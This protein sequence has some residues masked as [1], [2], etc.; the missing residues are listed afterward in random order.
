MPA[1]ATRGATL[2]LFCALSLNAGAT[3]PT[4]PERTLLSSP[5]KAVGE[6]QLTDQ[7]GRPF[8]SAQLLG[9]PTLVF[10]GFTNCPDVCPVTMQRLTLFKRNHPELA[11]VKVVMISVDGERDTPERMATYLASYSPSFIGLTGKPATVNRIAPE[12]TAA[13]FKGSAKPQGGY[14]V[15]HS[16]QVYL[17]D[18]GNRLTATFFDAPDA[19]MT[20]VIRSVM[21]SGP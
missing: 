14:D 13:F 3:Q 17:L 20:E 4:A 5:P 18:A 7:R 2:A 8:K 15:E 10:F 1:R 9:T 21:S 19:A 6:F 16:S 12:F 11:K